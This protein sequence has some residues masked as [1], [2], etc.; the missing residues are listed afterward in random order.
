MAMQDVELKVP[1]RRDLHA[2]DSISFSQAG[3]YFYSAA[4][5]APAADGIDRPLSVIFQETRRCNFDCDF[6]SETDQLADPTIEQIAAIEANLIG[7]PRVFL[8]GGE[9]LLRRDI[10]EITELFASGRVVAI[11]TNATR[12]H[13]LAGRLAGKVGFVNIS[14]EGPRHTTNRVRGDYDQVMR[15]ARAFVNAGIPVSVSAVVMRSELDAPSLHLPDRRCPRCRQ[16]QTDP[17]D[18]QGQRHP[19]RRQRVPLPGRVRAPLRRARRSPGSPRVDAG[20]AD[21]DM[22]T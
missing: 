10:V 11:P 17:P 7:V 14:L 18:P 21:D 13:R 16:A 1:A 6:C 4:D 20:V 2:N 15:G 22:D 8:S 19:P 3:H 5:G 9:P 12:G